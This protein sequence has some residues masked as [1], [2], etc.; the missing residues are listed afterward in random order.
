MQLK[1]G[2]ES[3]DT[4]GQREPKTVIKEPKQRLNMDKRNGTRT[5]K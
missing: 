2:I 1:K 3:R 4:E 5:K